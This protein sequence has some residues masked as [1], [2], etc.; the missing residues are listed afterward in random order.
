MDKLNVK[1][2]F[3][4]D[5]IISGFHFGIPFF[6]SDKINFEIIKKYNWYTDFDSLQINS[7]LKQDDKSFFNEL[8]FIDLEWIKKNNIFKI[9]KKIDKIFQDAY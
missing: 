3:T 7:I 6:F 1:H 9:K 8:Y 4:K 2:P 5:S